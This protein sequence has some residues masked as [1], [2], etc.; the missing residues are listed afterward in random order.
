MPTDSTVRQTRDRADPKARPRH[1]RYRRHRKIWLLGLI[2]P[3]LLTGG[4]IKRSAIVTTDLLEPLATPLPWL[5]TDADIAEE[6][7]F[8]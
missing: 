3:L 6:I 7:E 5:P 8:R 2:A 4:C 1:R